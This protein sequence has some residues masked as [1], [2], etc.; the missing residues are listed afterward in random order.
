MYKASNYV[1]ISIG[2]CCLIFQLGLFL[3]YNIKNNY[4]NTENKIYS[5][6]L[7]SNNITLISFI[8]LVASLYYDNKSLGTQFNKVALISAFSWAVFFALY[9]LL[10]T[11]EK[12]KKLVS[13]I[14]SNEKK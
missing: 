3:I 2:V 1:N 6:M 8:L 9:I 12:N 11:N 7:F 4:K 5:R 13:Y 14:R 10:I